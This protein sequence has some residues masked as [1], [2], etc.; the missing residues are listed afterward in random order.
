MKGLN[1]IPLRLSLVIVACILNSGC[2]FNDP[3]RP[4]SDKGVV[5][6]SDRVIAITSD[7]I[8]FFEEAADN[9]SKI[10]S[11][12]NKEVDN[13]E[14]IVTQVA[15][16]AAPVVNGTIVQA[17]DILISGSTAVIAYCDAGINFSGALQVID[18]SNKTQPVITEEW[19]FSTVEINAVL[20]DGNVI[21][22]G[23]AADPDVWGFKS[24]VGSFTI[25]QSSA[26]TVVQ[27]MRSLPSHALTAITQSGNNYYV[28]TG[29]LHG[30]VVNL[31][32][33]LNSVDSVDMPDARD[34]D[35]FQGGI[36]A[37]YGTTDHAV[38]KGALVI[39]GNDLLTKH[40]IEI[41]SFGSDYH[42]AT[43][44]IYAGQTA[45]CGLSAS[46]CTIIDLNTSMTLFSIANPAITAPLLSTTNSVSA[47]ANL[48][49]TANGNYGF[50]VFR[51]RNSN[52]SQTE[53]VGY[54]P[55]ETMHKNGIPYSANHIEFK[56]NYLFVASGV[57]GV[58]IYYLSS[59]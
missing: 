30:K 40:I 37:L 25:G 46:G 51:I 26:E 38:R 55:F 14:Y 2:L 39:T 21:V 28:S 48:L 54:Y 29:A 16:V 17:N 8:V 36:C 20:I 9:L 58:N 1:M 15:N 31:D 49:F 52:F 11:N 57:G 7:T 10:I 43:V 3:V 22:F 5:Y 19:K 24:C 12:G 6:S 23:G 27:S 53:L 42:K 56:S 18:I 32:K 33:K 50:R 44:E 35:A 13:F 41:D 34:I 47:D 4:E 59:K 45:L